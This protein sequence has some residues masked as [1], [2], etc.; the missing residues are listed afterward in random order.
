MVRIH[1]RKDKF[2]K[3]RQKK[4]HLRADGPFKILKKIGDNAY[5]VDLPDTYGVSNIFNVGDLRQHEGNTELGTILLKKRGTDPF[6]NGPQTKAITNDYNWIDESTIEIGALQLDIKVLPLDD[7]LRGEQGYGQ[8][9]Q[10]IHSYPRPIHGPSTRGVRT[11]LTIGN[12]R[13]N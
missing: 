6:R 10:K 4:L 13:T 2:P 8:E 3:H 9:Q 1:L 5:K 12:K 7:R 11:L